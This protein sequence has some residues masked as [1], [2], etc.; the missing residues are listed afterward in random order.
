[1]KFDPP[2][3]PSSRLLQAA[4]SAFS[5]SLDGFHDLLSGVVHANRDKDVVTLEW[6][7]DRPDWTRARSLLS[8]LSVKDGD[9]SE[10]IVRPK[11]Q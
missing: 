7:F 4:D 9:V 11:P 1:V 3:P 6:R 5:I 8:T 2:V 10:I